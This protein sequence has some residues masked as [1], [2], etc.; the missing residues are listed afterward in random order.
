[1]EFGSASDFWTGPNRLAATI[2]AKI[3]F[4]TA[5][6][7]KPKK[8]NNETF[9]TLLVRCWLSACRLLSIR[10]NCWKRQRFI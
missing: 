9:L 6:E 5:A 1:L 10:F 4:I 7:I 3:D 8:E 2:T